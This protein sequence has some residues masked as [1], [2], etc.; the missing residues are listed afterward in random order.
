MNLSIPWLAAANI[1]V[2]VALYL[3]LYAWSRRALNSR[4]TFLGVA[5]YLLPCVAFVGPFALF[6]LCERSGV[7]VQTSH[8]FVS[9]LFY[10]ALASFGVAGWLSSCVGKASGRWSQHNGA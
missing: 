1:A 6:G 8:G 7:I 4:S 3:A 5:L 9:L 10:A 2:V